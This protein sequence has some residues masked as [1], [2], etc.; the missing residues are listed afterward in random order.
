MYQSVYFESWASKWTTDGQ[1]MDLA[2]IHES[3]PSVNIVNL[4]FAS[5]TGKYKKGSFTFEDTGLQFSQNFSVVKQAIAVLTS[6]HC[7]VVLSVGGSDYP[8]NA[9]PPYANYQD[10]VDLASDL[11]CTGIDIDWEPAKGY[12]ASAD[13]GPLIAAFRRV[14]PTSMFLSAAVWGTGAY[15]PKPSDLWSGLNTVGL[16]THGGQLNCINIMA[17][18]AGTVPT[19][20]DP[21][22]SFASYRSIYKGAICLGIEPG[23]MG[24]G[25]YLTT[26][27]D[28]VD[29]CTCVKKDGNGGIFIW[30]WYKDTKGSPSVAEIIQT[31]KSIFN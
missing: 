27:K 4:A 5:P 13:F 24:W 9:T 10:M 1:K 23:P 26:Q 18:D 8:Y 2:L 31:A 15:P 16:R 19:D 7:K 28:V 20:F 6:N 3:Q 21:Q 17:Y 25:N 12:S 22:K 11:G 30:S 14:M 29:A